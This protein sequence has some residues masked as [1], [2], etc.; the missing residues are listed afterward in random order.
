MKWAALVAGQSQPLILSWAKKVLLV[1][2][3]VLDWVTQGSTLFARQSLPVSRLSPRGNNRLPRNER[4]MKSLR[5]IA[6]LIIILAFHGALS[7]ADVVPPDGNIGTKSGGRSTPITS[8]TQ[9]LTFSPC[10][11]ATGDVAFDCAL[12]GGAQQIFAGVNETGIPLDS[13]RIG[14]SGY[15]Q[16]LD[17]T[18][19]CDGGTIF[20]NCFTSVSG[21]TLTVNFLQGNG[22][23]IGCYDT[24]NQIDPS[25]NVTCFLNSEAAISSNRIHGTDLPYSILPIQSAGPC[26]PPEGFP[27]GAVCGSDEFVI[28][29]GYGGNTFNQPLS[30]DASF[31]ANAPEPPTLVLFGSAMLAMLLFGIKKV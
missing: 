11:G 10:A 14:F 25:L 9:A 12:F 21:S 1:R 5:R 20:Q 2:Q 4:I 3:L 15:S 31:T 19:N 22:T 24:S 6:V 30:L 8:L 18:V 27:P 28:G 29:I 17:P 13:I 23:G 16:T 7:F 26:E